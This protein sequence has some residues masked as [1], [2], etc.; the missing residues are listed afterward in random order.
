MGSLSDIRVLE[1]A[2]PYGAYAGK[3][4]ADL[5]A[6]VIHIEPPE[7]DPTRF[8][9]PFYKD[10]RDRE[11]SLKYLYHN[12]S[13]RG[14][15]LDITKPEGQE[16]FLRLVK[17]ADIVIESFNPGFMES[18]GLGY[19]SL[20]KVNPKIVYVSITPFGREGPYTDFPGSN[21]TVSALGG[22]LYLAG[23]GNNKPALAYG[24][25]AYM[26][27]F[28]YAASGAM[29]AF[30]DAEATGEGQVVEI[31]MQEAVVTACENACQY[32]DLEK[33]ERR[34]TEEIEAG[35]NVYECKDGF[36]SAMF[37][38]GDNVYL[39]D[40]FWQW[41]KDEGRPDLAE[42]FGSED[43][44]RRAYRATDE[45]KQ[46]FRE[47]A[48]PF[49]KQFDKTYIY[50]ETQKRRTV[51]Y[52]VNDSKDVYENEQLNYRNYFKKLYHESLGGEVVYPGEVYYL[53]KMEW[54]LKPAPAF[55][56]HTVEILKELG[57]ADEQVNT[58]KEGGVVI[59]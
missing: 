6:D 26:M 11:G 18:L 58:L 29:A 12:T 17:T 8:V 9:W 27:A 5:G 20:K 40:P 4:F 24:E 43:F 48:E 31:S 33:I 14:L 28:C 30:Y 53:E 50:L 37:S 56:Q 35:R 25:Q 19:E 54:G 42:I 47:K 7:G 10:K 16:V 45:A 21:L 49:I 38:M 39:W 52:P 44:R 22:W 59:G 1:F 57:Y 51:C 15:V 13:K 23:T 55:G 36:V 32:W 2:S 34:A 3:M 46:I 41:M